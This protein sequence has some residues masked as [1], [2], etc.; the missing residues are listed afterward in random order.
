MVKVVK[1]LRIIDKIVTII[2]FYEY[3]TMIKDRYDT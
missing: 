3:L 1:N 2:E